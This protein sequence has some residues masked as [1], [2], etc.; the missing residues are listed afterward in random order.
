MDK[1]V[2]SNRTNRT[3]SLRWRSIAIILACCVIPVLLFSG[4]VIFLI[5]DNLS[6]Q[7]Q[8][9]LI[10]DFDAAA[11]SADINLNAALH[12][13]RNISYDSTVKTAYENY[14]ETNDYVIFYNDI[15]TYL[16]GQFRYDD[17][18][19]DAW[20]FLLSDTKQILSASNAK[21]SSGPQRLQNYRASLH[22]SV[23]GMSEGL[24]T[25]VSFL[26]YTGGL[27]LIRNMVDRQYKPYAVIVLNLNTE[28]IFREFLGNLWESAG[29]A[30]IDGGAIYEKGACPDIPE[31][32]IQGI[33]I[34]KRSG[35]WFLCS[36]QTLDTHTVTYAASVSDSLLS[37]QFSSSY[38]YIVIFS[39]LMV[40][41][42]MAIF[43]RF[44][45]KNVNKPIGQLV[46]AARQ[47]EAGDLGYR[48]SLSPRAKELRY[49]NDSFNSMSEQLKALFEKSIEE[50]LALQ[51]A[52]IDALQSQ[53]DPHFLSNTLEIVKWEAQMEKADRVSLMIESLSTLLSAALSRD[54][55]A[56]IPLREEL[57]YLNAY[58]YIVTQR[59][60]TLRVEKSIDPALFDRPIP[61]LILQPLVENAVDYDRG[62]REEPLSDGS[63]IAIR[64][65][66]KEGTVYLEVEY[67]GSIT[68]EN[69]QAA[70]APMAGNAE[71]ITPESGLAAI[72]PAV[73]N[74]HRRIQLIYGNASGL[75]LHD[76]RAGRVIA[77][78]RIMP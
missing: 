18:V 25:D 40:V 46:E 6:N 10:N 17:N 74:V 49:L 39:I 70:I 51:D 9:E 38:Y 32:P 14:S 29:A 42:F 64:A 28:T 57:N 21:E 27:L 24:G 43:L 50:Q 52:R 23:I 67:D 59:Q 16:N 36:E 12:A 56:M 31:R 72:A 11:T 53:I 3:F 37:K 13:S 8:S 34:D 69:G 20:F 33:R 19:K 77:R 44:V 73:E 68:P 48:T 55:V 41:V 62:S 26:P 1:K 63:M 65:Y 22:D 35:N 71:S 78:I 75:T 47:I 66:E 61:R 2:K 7:T 15:A 76:T 54:G 30:F 4:V 45:V 60:K 5:E 58:L